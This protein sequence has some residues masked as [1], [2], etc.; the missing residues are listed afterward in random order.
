M[1]D[2]TSEAVHWLLWDTHEN[3]AV[4]TIIWDANLA[5]TARELGRHIEGP[6]RLASD[7]T[8]Q[9]IRL[10]VKADIRD[11]AYAEGERAWKDEV[12][13]LREALRWCVR[14]IE[15][16]V[17]EPRPE[18]VADQASWRA[19]KEAAFPLDTSALP[20]NEENR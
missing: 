20:P 14:W 4:A 1:S 2:V 19:A 12:E 17:E 8:D 6:F 13:R 5:D 9:N 18:E 3:P 15:F 7:M 10:R 11:R 16:T